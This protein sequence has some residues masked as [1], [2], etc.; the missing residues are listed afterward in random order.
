MKLNSQ[1]LLNFKT[2]SHRLYGT[3][4]FNPNDIFI[5][6]TINKQESW[7]SYFF[8]LF[9]KFCK[10]KIVLDIGANIG[11]H[12]L[13]LSRIAKKVVAFEPQSACNY[14]LLCNLRDNNVNN[15]QV[16]NY[17]LGEKKETKYFPKW[18]QSNNKCN[19]GGGSLIPHYHAI[20]D[21]GTGE[22]KTN[23]FTEYTGEQVEVITLD[24]L[25]I[26]DEISFIKID[27]EG[28]ESKFLK[29]AKETLARNKYPPILIEIHNDEYAKET[30]DI[31]YNMGY[32][33]KSNQS[34]PTWD[35]LAVNILFRKNEQLLS[36]LF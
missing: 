13:Y 10:D 9:E 30:L 15:V 23:S 19:F 17:A 21:E 35:K 16:Y 32:N 34:W 1:F 14:A 20:G 29:G 2:V 18:A 3:V 27:I 28:Y 22:C 8:P 4:T 31:L 26:Q 11:L 36:I 33:V 12:T 25:N 7:E 24:E 5:G 6:E